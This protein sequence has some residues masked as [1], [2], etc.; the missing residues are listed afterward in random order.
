M[1]L[2][3]ENEA[4]KLCVH[5]SWTKIKVQNVVEWSME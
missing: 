5:V 4:V 2:T 3:A 1:L